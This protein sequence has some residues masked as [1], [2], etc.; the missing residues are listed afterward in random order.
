MRMCMAIVMLVASSV[1]WAADQSDSAPRL[2]KAQDLPCDV[3]PDALQRQFDALQAMQLRTLQYSL[4][5]PVHYIKGD[6]GVVLP[7]YV[8]NLKEGDSGVE[9]LQLFKDILLASGTETLKVTRSEARPSSARRLVF[10]QSIRGIPVI[11]GLVAVE[12]DDA[13]SRVSDFIAN[14]V[15]DRGLTRDPKISATRAEQSVAETL[16]L[17]KDGRA[18]GMEI[19]AGTYLGYYQVPSELTAPYLVWVVSVE[20]KGEH[21]LFIVDAVTGIVVDGKLQSLRLTRT[22]YNANNGS[23]SIPGGL[24]SPMSP[25]QILLDAWA[26]EAWVDIADADS[27]LR[28]RLNLPAARFPTNTHQ[29]VR[30]VHAVPTAEYKRVGNDDYISYSPPSTT[31]NSATGPPDVTY[32]EYAH[33]VGK[34]TLGFDGDFHEFGAL[35]EAFADIGAT[36]VDVAIRGSPATETWRIAEGFYVSGAAIR[37]MANPS[38]DSNPVSGDWF[39]HRILFGNVSHFNSTILSHAYFLSING[40]M[41]SRVSAPEIPE[42]TVPAL[43]LF[44][45]DAEARARQIFAQAFDDASMLSE[46]TLRKMKSAA[47]AKASTMFGSEAQTSIQAAFEAVG[48]CRTSS[49]PPT[50]WPVVTVVDHYCAGQFDMSWPAMPG[51]DRYYAEVTNPQ[52]GWA[53]AQPIT[54]INGTQCSLQ[55][56]ARKYHRM[57]ACNDCGCGPWGPTRVLQYWVP[58]L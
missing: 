19:I 5:G 47:M 18:E 8:A 31:T 6:T 4:R 34:R 28:L 36:V 9:F 15:P 29:V 50:T 21:E 49:D 56:P 2:L 27:K 39:P 33:G 24:P 20:F 35:H 13:T 42:T 1:T 25:S 11:D 41:H 12:Y 26:Y 54:D 37:S 7:S 38:V 55:L 16:A 46:P 48:I 32:H 52:F 45:V 17:A 51:V 23:P 40:G 53:F 58:C 22:V 10:S 43:H 3:E 57:R 44:P 30:Y 14:F